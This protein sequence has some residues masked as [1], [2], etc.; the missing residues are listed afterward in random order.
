[1]S[2]GIYLT[3]DDAPSQHL[4]T[5]VDF[6]AA[7]GIPALFFCRGDSIQP[8]KESLIQAIQK[9][10]WVGNHA[11]SHP[12]FSQISFEECMDE[13]LK[14]EKL[15]HACYQ[16]AGVPRPAKF[17]RL[18]YGDRGAGEG[19]RAA[20]TSVEAEKVESIQKFLQEEGFQPL[21]F[22]TINDPMIDA[23]WTWNSEDYKRVF[24]E[25]PTLYEEALQLYWRLSNRPV[26]VILL[27]DFQNNHHL[28]E[29][30]MQFLLGKKVSFLKP[31]TSRTFREV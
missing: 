11:Y 28:F 8:H 20:Q 7:R 19:A 21:T 3:I 15:I 27:H 23:Y 22:L 4:Q 29:R 2:K 17:I 30:T 13:V 24:I 25:N 18:P 12:Y 9:G 14:T 31:R 16:A 5:K 26:E 6:L 1:M 10:F